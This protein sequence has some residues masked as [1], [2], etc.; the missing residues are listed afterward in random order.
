MTI[1]LYLFSFFSNLRTI[2]K[3]LFRLITSGVAC[4]FFVKS[5]RSDDDAERLRRVLLPFDEQDDNEEDENEDV[6]DDEAEDEDEDE[7]DSEV[8]SFSLLEMYTLGIC[9]L[10]D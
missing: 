9:A 3:P 1:I 10:C 7:D 8:A 5:C 2:T 6:D 4:C